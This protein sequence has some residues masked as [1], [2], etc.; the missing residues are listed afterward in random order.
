MIY[1]A[2]VTVKVA[3]RATARVEKGD[4]GLTSGSVSHVG[5]VPNEE[6]FA[7]AAYWAGIEA[8]VCAMVKMEKALCSRPA[9]PLPNEHINIS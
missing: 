4:D 2:G 5:R 8:F 7:Y 9:Y 1:I 3:G 6:Q